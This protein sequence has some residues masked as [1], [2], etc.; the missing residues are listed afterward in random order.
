[1]YCYTK[2]IQF[3]ANSIHVTVWQQYYVV[4]VDSVDADGGLVIQC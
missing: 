4:P 3:K 2:C 1:M